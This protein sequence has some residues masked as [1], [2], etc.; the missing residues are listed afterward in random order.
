MMNINYQVQRRAAIVLGALDNETRIEIV[1]ILV[2]DGNQPLKVLE[3]KLPGIKKTNI[4]NHIAKLKDAALISFTKNVT[5]DGKTYAI[6]SV[7]IQKIESVVKLANALAAVS[8]GDL[9]SSKR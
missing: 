9:F 4:L 5:P 1:R 3:K 2:M 8:P 6:Y 7:E